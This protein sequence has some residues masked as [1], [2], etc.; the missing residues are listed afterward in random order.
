MGSYGSLQ[1]YL[2]ELKAASVHTGPYSDV[3]SLGATLYFALTLLHPPDACL[4]QLGENLRPIREINPDVPDFLVEA[5]ERALVVDPR[6]RLQSAAEVRALL[7]PQPSETVPR[8]LPRQRQ[9]PLPTG[10]VVALGHELIYIPGGEFHMGSND[11]DVKQACRPGHRV[12]V[13]P[14]CIARLPVTHADYQ[15]FV[16]ENADYPVPYS[17]MRYAQRYNW[18]RRAR[19]FPRGLEDHP[20]VLVAWEDALA[21]CRWLSQVSG[22]R[23]RLPTEAEWEKAATWDAAA[24][25][26]RLYPWGDAFDEDQCNVDAHG[27]LRLETSPVGRYSPAGD[28]PYGLADMAGNVWEWTGS[29]Y[30]P[31]PYDSGDGRE[32]LA[33]EGERVVRGGSYDESPLL[34]HC[35][36]RNGVDPTL[37][38]ANIG[39]RVAC[40]AG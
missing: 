40:D 13:R 24:G 10:D 30:R 14:F 7:Q 25:Q 32:D 5:L 23:C 29:L 31:Y 12:N 1:H 37:R 6:A 36:W 4:R 3:Y 26:A 18:D 16:E 28:S 19:T 35:A 8:R 20:V 34:A 39:F 9:R 2:E 27:A 38:A 15:R 11:A 17:P 22:Y 21:Y 33:V